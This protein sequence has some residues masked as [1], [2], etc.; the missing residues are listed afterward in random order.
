M[1]EGLH[2]TGSLD[3]HTLFW[4]LREFKVIDKARVS[5]LATDPGNRFICTCAVWHFDSPHK[6]ICFS[7]TTGIKGSDL[8]WL[9]TRQSL[10]YWW[11]S[12]SHH[13]S[14]TSAA[15]TA[16]WSPTL[17]RGLV[18]FLVFSLSSLWP[19]EGWG[20]SFWLECLGTVGC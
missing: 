3:A 1:S 17:F 8:H 13:F 7:L 6:H 18:I 16:T 14:Y 19:A 2:S 4:K 9:Q 20:T 12:T 10:L 5:Q 15:T 11:F